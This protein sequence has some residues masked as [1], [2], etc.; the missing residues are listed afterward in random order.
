M[1]CGHR[2]TPRRNGGAL[3]IE[4]LRIYGDYGTLRPPGPVGSAH[5]K[6]ISL[7]RAFH[8]SIAC[9]LT[10][11]LAKVLCGHGST[12]RRNGGALRIKTHRIYGVLW[13]LCPVGS[14][15]P[16]RIALGRAFQRS[17][18]QNPHAQY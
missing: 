5:S 8:C 11:G 1:L 7:G 4:T 2:S 18:V 10:G 17:I 6:R 15:H 3:R 14:A 13:F 12:P 9:V 16:K